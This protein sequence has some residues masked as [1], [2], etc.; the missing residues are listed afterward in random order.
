M[1]YLFSFSRYQTKRVIEFVFRQLMTSWTLKFIFDHPLKQWPTGRK[2]WNDRNTKRWISQE[3][4]EI[5][6][7]FHSFWRAIIWWKNKNLIKIADTSFNNINLRK[8]CEICSI[9]TLKT[10]ERRHWQIHVKIYDL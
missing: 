8:R 9:L 5:K 2:T 1:S 7:S 10:L 4:K 6:S 3:P